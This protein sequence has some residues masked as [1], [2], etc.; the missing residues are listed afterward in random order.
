MHSI[1]HPLQ[2]L[3]LTV[4]IAIALMDTPQVVA[5]WGLV[6]FAV[7]TH[8]RLARAL[9]SINAVLA[10]LAMFSILPQILVI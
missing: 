6:I 8:V 9:L 10:T 7:I 2:L 5:Q 3:L 4:H 1:C